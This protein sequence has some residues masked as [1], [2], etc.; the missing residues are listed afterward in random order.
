MAKRGKP[1]T[2]P[3]REYDIVR[4]GIT[5]GLLGRFHHCRQD[6]RW[7]LK[8]FQRMGEESLPLAFGNVAHEMF[9]RIYVDIR[10]GKLTKPP[11]QKFINRHLDDI[12][13]TWYQENPRASAKL[14]TVMASALG[15][16]Q[17]IVPVYF[18]KWKGDF[19]RQWVG[20][21]REFAI[22]YTLEDGRRTVLR[23]KKDAVFYQPRKTTHLEKGYW[24]LETKTKSR[25]DEAF[26]QD[27]L[28]WDIQSN[29][30]MWAIRKTEKKRPRGVLYNIVRRPQ[31]RLKK[32]ESPSQFAARCAGDVQE[33]PDFYFYRIKC[34]V[35]RQDL[36]RFEAQLEDMV[37][38]F[39]DWWEGLG[40]HYRNS[41]GCETKYGVCDWFEACAGRMD[42]YLREGRLFREL[43]FRERA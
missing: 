20:V 31:L 17:A 16:T 1:K 8:G 32:G 38:E 25:V 39:Y 29:M 42:M 4:D 3:R 41:N 30:Y 10:T 22:P 19:N 24:L 13:K 36:Y 7:Y 2:S 6:S 26:L 15:F 14:T 40:P 23:G 18:Q 35:D 5:Q 28:P 11:S 34:V 21:E 37:K 9:E 27:W 12:Q 33:R 43:D